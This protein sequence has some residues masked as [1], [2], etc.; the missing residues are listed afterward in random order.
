[1]HVVRGI[2]S[3]L[4]NSIKLIICAPG[5]CAHLLRPYGRCNPEVQQQ[6]Q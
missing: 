4:Y 1:M 5:V 3:V 6:Q 2:Y